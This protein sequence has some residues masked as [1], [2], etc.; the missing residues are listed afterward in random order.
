MKSIYSEDYKI[1]TNLLKEFREKKGKTQEQ[2][3]QLLDSD[4]TLISRY[5]NGQV[6]LDMIQ[7]YYYLSAMGVPMR[8]FI[9]EFLSVLKPTGRIRLMSEAY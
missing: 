6:R 1:F 5:E 3:A 4:R 2:L 8:D 7:I 9:E